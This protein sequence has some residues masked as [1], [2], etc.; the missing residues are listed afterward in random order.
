MRQLDLFK[1]IK[2][3]DVG[4][5]LSKDNADSES[6]NWSERAYA[7]L[8]NYTKSNTEFM[9][10]DVRN[11]SLGIVP[12]PPS[13]RAWG[14][15]FVTAKKNGLLKRIGYSCVRNPKAHRTPATLWG[16]V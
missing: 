8:L 11:A 9:A 10:E 16:V 1:G 13:N 2:A 3:R 4:I 7:F 5:K 6:D 15:V 12:E 14:S